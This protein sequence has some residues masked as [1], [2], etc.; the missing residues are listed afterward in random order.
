LWQVYIYLYTSTY[1]TYNIYIYMSRDLLPKLAGAVT[2]RPM[3]V[4]RP[5]A[6]KAPTTV[7][8]HVCVCVCARARAI[9]CVCVCVCVCRE[10]ERERERERAREREREHETE[11]REEEEE[12]EEEDFLLLRAAWPAGPPCGQETQ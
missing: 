7:A 5:R 10:R 9:V 4:S 6:P 2:L 3:V 12:E 8:V 1:S 11:L